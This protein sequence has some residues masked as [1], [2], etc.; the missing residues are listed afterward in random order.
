MKRGV[1]PVILTGLII[2]LSLTSITILWSAVKPILDT[3]R[4]D[5]SGS[6]CLTLVVTP[7]SCFANETLSI[8]M[9]ERAAGEGVFSRLRFVFDIGNGLVRTYDQ[10]VFQFDQLERQRFGFPL[11]IVSLPNSVDIAPVLSDGT[12]CSVTH[13]PI[14][15]SSGDP[16]LDS[17]QCND[18]E[19]NDY[20]GAID[21]P[22]DPGCLDQFDDDE[23][24]EP[25]GLPACRD[26]I[27]NGD[28]DNWIDDQDPGCLYPNGTYNPEDT[29]EVFAGTTE[30]SDEQDNGDL[31]TLVDG[32]DSDCTSWQNVSEGYGGDRCG[33]PGTD[34]YYF[35]S[36][37]DLNISLF[38][39]GT[40]PSFSAFHIDSQTV[41]RAN[42]SN[43]NFFVDNS[44]G[45]LDINYTIT[46][47]C[48]GI[49]IEYVVANPT[50]SAQILPTLRIDGL[51]IDES[52]PAY[53]LN[54][55]DSGTLEL[56]DPSE[57]R[58]L[59]SFYPDLYSP[60]IVMQ[61]QRVS[62]GS[63]LLYDYLDLK[64]TTDVTLVRVTTGLQAGTWRQMYP[65]ASDTAN[66]IPPGATHDYRVSLRFS[67][68]RYYM[69]TL[70][71]Y[72]DFFQSTYGSYSD[73]RHA[74]L[75]PIFR[76]N[77]A[78]RGDAFTSENPRGYNTNNGIHDQGWSP[79]VDSTLSSML[80]TDMQ[81]VNIWLPSGRYNSTSCCNFPP[82]F[83][84]WLPHLEDSASELERFAHNGI[85]LGYWWGRSSEVPLDGSGNVL[86][87]GVWGPRNLMATNFS[88][89]T[90]RDFMIRQLDLSLE[91]GAHTVGL[92]HFIDS[93]A[94]QR[95]QWAQDMKNYARVNFDREVLYIHEG[96]GP[97]FMHSVIG[98][99]YFPCRW[100]KMYPV[101]P[102]ELAA[103]LGNRESEVWLSLRANPDVSPSSLC[104]P[105]NFIEPTPAQLQ[106]VIDWGYTP[107]ILY[108]T[109]MSSLEYRRVSCFDGLDN[110][111]DDLIDYPYDSDCPSSSADTE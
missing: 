3:T 36:D 45:F 80:S 50:L 97:D 55:K 12:V 51:K 72:K 108:A 8:V 84:D 101:G 110:D 39:K 60:V 26:G 4:E 49:D 35:L 31:D 21:W 107:I 27:D 46:K 109:D 53:Y 32:F 44:G 42:F 73:S 85:S 99:W 48:G 38:M 58:P 24:N 69:T 13:V 77:L 15:C 62:S 91:R 63:S 68:P 28:G 59:D 25:G 7:V 23:F 86:G 34:E 5:V 100:D 92:D 103:Y 11:T 10:E 98:N 54:T 41:L 65:L 66:R 43:E 64:H 74:D 75:R 94:W 111:N 95:Y 30:C 57:P 88:N 33:E 1:S 22:A 16:L 19:D 104:H 83:M 90:H 79:F 52:V 40:S 78:N 61:D 29:S 6:S 9:V 81:R 93:P 71:P 37:D 105:D 76:V 96:S 17:F 47:V 89:Q 56:L 106:A 87:P 20:D 2:I 18:G 82:Q 70:K 102:D 67:E 14:T